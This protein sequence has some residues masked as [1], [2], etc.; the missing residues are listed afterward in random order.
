MNYRL[1]HRLLIK[2]VGLWCAL[3]FAHLGLAAPEFVKND[4]QWD[5]HIRYR[6]ELP[7]ATLW[8]E[9]NA[10][11]YLLLG[12]SWTSFGH[13][14]EGLEDDYSAHAYRMRFLGA[15]IP[16][17]S[18]KDPYS[19]SYN[20]FRGSDESRWK[21]GVKAFERIKYTDLYQ[22][23]DL[24]IYSKGS[25]LKYD[26]NVRPGGDV[27]DVKF[28]YEGVDALELVYGQLR[29]ETSVRTI[30]EMRPYAYQLIDGKLI[31]VDCEFVV[32]GNEV[33]FDVGEYNPYYALVIDPEITFASYIGST[34]SNFGFTATDDPDGNLIAGACIFGAGY[35]TTIGA[36]QDSWDIITNGYC[37]VGISKFS[38]DGSQLMYS[39]YLGGD[40]LEMP[41]S[42]IADDDGNF[43]VMG[44]TG[45]LNFPTSGGAYQPTLNG[46]PPFPFS[47][48]F[49]NATHQN[50][51]DF[52]VTKFN[53]DDSGLL[54]ST[55]IGGND[56]DGL[57]VA[58]KLFY[59][60]GDSFRGEV[61]IDASGSIVVASTTYS[62]DF[63]MGAPSPLMSNTGMQDGIVFRLNED[64]T[65]LQWASYIGGTADDAAYSVQQDSNGGL[66]VTG[67]TKSSFIDQ[68]GTPS[69]DDTY[70]GDVDAFVVRF[71]LDGG[72]VEAATYLGTTAYEQAY[73]VQLDADDNIYLIGQN[74]GDLEIIGGVYGNP[75]S[76]QFI[77]KYDYN[78]SAIQW[79]TTIGTGSGAIDISPT[80]F[81]VS[82]CGQIYFSG[83]GG[84]TNALNSDYANQSTTIGLPITPNAQQTDTDGSDFYLAVL[85]A[86]A[87]D[88]MYATFFGG[89]TSREHVDGGT[90]KFDKDFSVYQSVCAGCGG[91]DDFPTTPNA[92]SNDNA[93]V[94]CNLGVF[95]FDLG[96]IEAQIDI[97]GPAEVC[98]GSI[99]EFVNNTSG[100][101][102]YEWFFGDDNSSTQFEPDH[103][104]EANGT[105]EITLIVSDSG[106]CLESDTAYLQI[107]VLPGVNPTLEEI[108]PI[109]EGDSVQL[110]VNG[111]DNVYWLDD[112]TLSD[113]SIPNPWATPD[114]PTTYYAVDFNDCETDT[115]G[116]VVDWIQVV[117]NISDDVTICV[118]QSTTLTAEG[119]V[120]Y[121]WTPITGLG[122]P[123]NAETTA[124]PEETIT[125]TVEITTADGCLAEESVTVNV[126]QDFPGG[127]VYDPVA[128]CN[129]QYTTLEA[130]DGISW[131]WEPA[132]Y[133]DNPN[134]QTPIVTVPDTTLFTVE[135]TNAC[136][137][138]EDQVWVNVIIPNVEVGNDGSVCFG[139][140]YPVSAWGAETYQWQPAYLVANDEAEQTFVR[141][142]DD[143]VF[144][145][146]GTDEYGCV[147]S[148]E[149][150]VDVL[151]LPYVNAGPDRVL[152][153]LESDYLFGTVDDTEFWW[154]PELYMDCPDCLTPIITPPESLWYVLHTIDANG[155][156]GKDSVFVDVFSPIYVPNTFT[157]D[158]D[159]INDIFLPVGA[160]IR[161]FRMEIYNR[162]GELIF[163]TEDPEK[164]WNGSVRG[165]EHYVQI[166]TYVWIVYHDTKEGREKLVGHV[167]V[168]R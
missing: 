47:T 107:E 5:E 159:G 4:G 56:T 168:I 26:V 70:N 17:I 123:L 109:C 69:V 92:W 57:N 97:D 32:D 112:P 25:N 82:D 133:C 151:P 45:S 157:P 28:G 51:C 126:D 11:T 55:Y 71:S 111:S 64:L 87:E 121:V 155:C 137:T 66:I 165:G 23:I 10:L 85:T 88:L 50:G 3:L 73:F 49:V 136:G 36:I 117:T 14:I 75:G 83:W 58:D 44:T 98:E 54:A 41:H 108:D 100:G 139:E 94:N 91:N 81:L 33:S 53:G 37:D 38:A 80:A 8:M 162:W 78:L 63:P 105:F 163:E 120:D 35:P 158:N 156:I 79:Q 77:V 68:W 2:G 152:E 116:V 65:A 146:Y 153:Y 150:F 76:G 166:D 119:G 52:F 72:N 130:L 106:D 43:V 46:G 62:N 24:L 39:T 143:Q 30:V 61:I 124:S 20:Y 95:K 167:N 148:A 60:Y 15:S 160:N 110:F 18:G 113:T 86:N 134:S 102:S 89:G 40:G 140:W 122:S 29:I 132:E 142:V 22:N 104:Y 6:T 115:I 21:Q 149:V 42:I 129:G 131:S 84:M 1:I 145:V 59:N 74:E 13:P 48:F 34:A 127:N 12:H 96:R 144:T 118:G 67:G 103:I 147:A 161:G 101:D 125:Y 31:E 16:T 128:V 114:A 90:S 164:G 135:V 138:G 93:S 7:G 154:E 19:Q 141:P 27:S 99:A 9:D